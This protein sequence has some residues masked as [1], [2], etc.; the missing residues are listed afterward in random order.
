MD[1]AL[2]G[3]FDEPLEG[4]LTCLDSPPNFCSG[5]GK[6]KVDELEGTGDVPVFVTDLLGGGSRD[7][8][9]AENAQGSVHVEMAGDHHEGACLSIGGGPI[10]EMLA[11]NP[12]LNVKV[13]TVGDVSF[14]NHITGTSGRGRTQELC[15]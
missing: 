4:N 5:K 7:M 1:L 6:R 3:S 13:K 11:G 10:A 2:G 14:I 12:V 9:S 15:E 8:V